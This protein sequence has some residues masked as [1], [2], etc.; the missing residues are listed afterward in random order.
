M[1]FIV[2]YECIKCHQLVL[3]GT[4]CVHC[5]AQGQKSPHAVGEMD[6]VEVK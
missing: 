1:G 2:I 3:D 6:P 5:G 4:R